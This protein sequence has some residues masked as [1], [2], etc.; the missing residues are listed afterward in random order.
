MLSPGIL[1]FRVAEGRIW[2]ELNTTFQERYL[3]VSFRQAWSDPEA[4]SK[5]LLR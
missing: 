1:S 4:D 2:A 3:K 5:W